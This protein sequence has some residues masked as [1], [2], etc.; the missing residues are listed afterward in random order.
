VAVR[1]G[2][3]VLWSAQLEPRAS[4]RT[5]LR[6]LRLAPGDTVWKF[7]T[8]RPP[9]FPSDYDRRR[10]AFSL[11]DLELDLVRRAEE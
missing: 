2:D 5:V 11:R 4:Q 6:G 10:I 3:R 1:A 7:E 9:E 8:D